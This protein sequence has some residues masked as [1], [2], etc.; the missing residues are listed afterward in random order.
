M[1]VLP[2][3]FAADAEQWF[4]RFERE[5]RALA[6]LNHP[7]I[8]QIYRF[9]DRVLVM[10]LGGGVASARPSGS[11]AVIPPASASHRPSSALSE[12][13]KARD[14][15]GSKSKNGRSVNHRPR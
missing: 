6:A 1:K 12:G 13:E 14:R 10:E 8:A 11:G 3:L 7:G 15:T 9:E 2:D 5:A 4:A